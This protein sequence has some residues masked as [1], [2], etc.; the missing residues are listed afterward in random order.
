[1]E[2]FWTI[3]NAILVF[4][5]L[6]AAFAAADNLI[7][8]NFSPADILLAGILCYIYLNDDKET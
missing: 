3:C 4:F 7:D 1:M 5:T 2:G 6:F 8:T